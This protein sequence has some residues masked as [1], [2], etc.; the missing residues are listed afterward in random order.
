MAIFITVI[1]A[2]S[3]LVQSNIV[4]VND[5][6]STGQ[7]IPFFVAIGACFTVAMQLGTAH[8]K[9]LYGATLHDGADCYYQN[10]M[11]KQEEEGEQGF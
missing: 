3:I 5:I 2:E 4:E 6:L 9:K 1:C 10:D 8:R 7:F 11:R